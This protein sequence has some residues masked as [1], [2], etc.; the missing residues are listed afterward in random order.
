MELVLRIKKCH[1]FLLTGEKGLY[2]LD[3]LYNKYGSPKVCLPESHIPTWISTFQ[4]YY[5][6][7][8]GALIAHNGFSTIDVGVYIFLI[9]QRWFFDK[10]R[11]SSYNIVTTLNTVPNFLPKKHKINYTEKSISASLKKLESLEFVQKCENAEKKSTGGSPAK[12]FYETTKII[13]LQKSIQA[14]LD[15][16]REKVLNSISRLADIEESL[17][18]KDNN[19]KGGKDV[20][21]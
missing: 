11:Y 10:P 2:D 7:Y 5:D 16:H 13:D 17:S 9:T 8:G 3:H 15:N 20:R 6:L 21:E 4:K 1:T 18:L 12:A 14:Q 19:A